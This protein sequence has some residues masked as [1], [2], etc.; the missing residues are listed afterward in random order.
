MKKISNIFIISAILLIS[1]IVY[2][3]SDNS[4][5]KW[6]EIKTGILSSFSLPVNELFTKKYDSNVMQLL[7][8]QHLVLVFSKRTWFVLRAMPNM[9]STTMEPNKIIE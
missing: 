6:T 7:E 2:S 8:H 9:Q 4:N 3:Q 1:N 5:D